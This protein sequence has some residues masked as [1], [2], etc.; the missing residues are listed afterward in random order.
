MKRIAPALA[1]SL[2][3]AAALAQYPAKPIRLIVPFAA[4]GGNDNV[5]RL[6]GKHLSDSLGRQLVIDNRP[7]AGGALGAELASWRCTLPFRPSPSRP[8]SLSRAPGRGSSITPRTATAARRI[9]PR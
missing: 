9:S 3:A 6:V 7:G 4:G 2:V 5:A 8:S 1:A